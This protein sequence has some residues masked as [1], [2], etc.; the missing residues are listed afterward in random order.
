MYVAR[1][2]LSIPYFSFHTGKQGPASMKCLIV[3]NFQLLPT[4]SACLA[5]QLNGQIMPG[6]MFY[7][8]MFWEW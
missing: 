2:Y 1:H 5:A 6:E 7:F 4:V 8:D 3:K